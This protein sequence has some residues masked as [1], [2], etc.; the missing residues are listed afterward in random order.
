MTHP[1]MEASDAANPIGE[2]AAWVRARRAALGLT[3]AGLAAQAGCSVVALRKLEE[4]TRRPSA[5]LA[6][7]LALALR[8]PP[9]TYAAFVAW[10]RGHAGAAA[11]LEALRR[12]ELAE[13]TML[14]PLSHAPLPAAATSFVGRAA[15]LAAIQARV[16]GPAGAGLL[17]LTGPGGVGKTRLALEAAAALQPAF[18]HG[19]CFV[20]LAALRDPALVLPAIARAMGVPET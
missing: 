13:T 10:A 1:P 20:P 3:R 14:G 17:T 19:V 6:T 16:G 8:L 5:E 12:A 2:F 4:G 15:E 18:P 9:A 11:L 7:Q